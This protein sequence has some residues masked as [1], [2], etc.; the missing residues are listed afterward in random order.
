RVD[1]AAPPLRVEEPALE[2]RVCKRARA[3]IAGGG[4]TGEALVAQDTAGEGARVARRS[5]PGIGR[6]SGASGLILL[7]HPVLWSP[8]ASAAS[9][10]YCCRRAPP[11]SAPR[12]C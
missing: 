5:G 12:R 11:R 3:G 4:E 7:H 10:L 2:R 8:I 1:K 9:G 6:R